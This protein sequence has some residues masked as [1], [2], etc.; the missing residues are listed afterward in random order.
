MAKKELKFE[1]YVEIDWKKLLPILIGL[2]I[3]LII[4]GVSAY[5]Y[6]G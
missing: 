2:S 3:G 4:V 6:L 5:Y 1:K